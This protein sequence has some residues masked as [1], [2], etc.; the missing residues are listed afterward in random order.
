MKHNCSFTNATA[1]DLFSV[2][3]NSTNGTHAA[4]ASRALTLIQNALGIM[5]LI[6]VMTT[7]GCAVD[8]K[9]LVAHLKKPWAILVGMSCQYIVL[10]FLGFCGA[11]AFSLGPNQAVAFMICTS[12]PGGPLS[13]LMTLGFDGD[14]SLRYV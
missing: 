10:P 7:S 2:W 8:M 1:V 12:S 5:A 9:E 4:S 13:N 11:L 6:L 3:N 14:L